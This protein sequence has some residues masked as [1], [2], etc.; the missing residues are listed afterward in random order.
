MAMARRAAR[1]SLVLLLAATVAAPAAP[2]A[3]LAHREVLANGIRLLVAPR[4]GVPIVVVRVFLRAGSAFDPPDAPGLA[5]LTAE[6]LT[7]GTARHTAPEIDRAI[8][9][10]GGVLDADCGRDGATVSLS[11]LKK[12]LDLGLDLLAEVLLTPAFPEDELRRQVTEIQA[13]LQRSEEN[14]EVLAGRALA[15]LLYPGHPYGHPVP[16]TV[17][18][19]GK[20]TREQV[21]RFHRQHY[22]PDAAAIA[23]VGDVSVDAVR[24]AILR[25]L[26]SWAPPGEPLTVVPPAPASPPVASETIT[27]SD[28]TQATVYLGRPA[29]N[30]GHPDYF[31]LVV[32]NY[33]LGGGSTSRLYTRVR[34]ERGLA[35]SVFSGLVPARYGASDILTLQTRTDAVG[36]A[37]KV[38]RDEM[39]AMAR[40]P[41]DDRELG[42]ARAYLVGSFPR[43]LDTSQKLADF[44]IGMEEQGLGLDYPERFKA[45]IAAVTAADVE[46]V[47][48]RYLDPATFSTVIVGK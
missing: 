38:V 35:Y 39:A 14:P 46:R 42:L 5:N 23:A 22:R 17:E 36:E 8:E 41:V 45:G 18:S 44:L 30:Q 16:G 3:P 6:L 10:V 11:I 47:A 4:P 31:P 19:V 24:E 26:G 9:F 48:A 13:A 34:E 28:L 2:A 33:V 37:A 7:R 1:C 43:R 15:R 21:V 27:R 25:R 40:A 12:D 29:V 32:A 20:L